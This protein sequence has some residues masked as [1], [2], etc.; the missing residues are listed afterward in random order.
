MNARVPYLARLAGQ[1]A[2][3]SYPASSPALRPPRRVLG[4]VASP[5]TGAREGVPGLSEAV[6]G[7]VTVPS[8]VASGEP[9]VTVT[10]RPEQPPRAPEVISSAA[11]AGTAGSFGA[12]EARLALADGRDGAF[13]AP[14]P[15]T[16][17]VVPA[18]AAGVPLSSPAVRDTVTPGAAATPSEVMP[19]RLPSSW[20]DPAWNEPVAVPGTGPVPHDKL[21]SR[22]LL[23][24]Q[25]LAGHPDPA[26]PSGPGLG[27]PGPGGPGP[28]GA[29]SDAQG[30]RAPRVSIGA[31]E[32]TV[33]P[34]ARPERIQPA[35]PPPRRLPRPASLLT[36]N[37]GADRLRD[38]LRRW[39]GTAQ[40]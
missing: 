29:G 15:A 40:G 7:A 39:H 12:P 26:V 20:A 9:V 2:S 10:A 14:Q 13:P 24:P 11:G 30:T 35:P 31:I 23:P 37:A 3:P 34:P 4:D 33:V 18:P 38:G 16:D 19:G 8:A 22:E 36:G 28:G 27:G 1:V 32:V 25:E 6:T 21:P 5:A 17:A